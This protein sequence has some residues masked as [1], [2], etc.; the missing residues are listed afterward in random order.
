VRRDP[1]FLARCPARARLGVAAVHL[2][3][4]KIPPSSTPQSLPNHS[5]NHRRAVV[6][7]ALALWIHGVHGA[8][9]PGRRRGYAVFPRS[10][11][12]PEHLA[13]RCL[14]AQLHGSLRNDVSKHFAPIVSRY[15]ESAAASTST[16]PDPAQWRSS[17]F[18]LTPDTQYS[19]LCRHSCRPTNPA[20]VL[21]T[22][23]RRL[24]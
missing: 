10:S 6:F 16:L 20:P 1:S 15:S 21:C 3:R 19:P 14:L 2:R 9:A 18:F 12:S 4:L 24:R 8:A 11:C 7:T 13:S 5:Q 23:S 17:P 22:C